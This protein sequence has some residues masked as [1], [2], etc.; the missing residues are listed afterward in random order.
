MPGRPFL[1]GCPGCSMSQLDFRI[2]NE[3]EKSDE[4]SPCECVGNEADQELHDGS[5]QQEVF[6]V[7]YIG[8]HEYRQSAG[9]YNQQGKQKNHGKVVGD[10]P[11]YGTR[12][13]DLPDG[14]EAPFDV[15][16]Q[17]Q[18]TPHQHDQTDADED[19]ALGMLEVRL[20][21]GED[22]FAL[23]VGHSLAQLFFDDGIEAEAPGYGEE[24]GQYRDDGSRVL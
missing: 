17:D 15:V 20:N 21:P 13:L 11:E 18:D 9:D 23:L 2:G 16:G 6:H 12:A 4:H 7:F 8:G 19:S 5:Q 10:F 1:P 22:E 24:D 14:I 3:N